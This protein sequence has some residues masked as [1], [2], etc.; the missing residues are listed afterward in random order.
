MKENYMDLC[1]L[2]WL[3]RL[4]FLVLCSWGVGDLLAEL[5]GNNII[6]KC[7]SLPFIK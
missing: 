5:V 7:Y 6:F 4:L 3:G 1:V 2:S